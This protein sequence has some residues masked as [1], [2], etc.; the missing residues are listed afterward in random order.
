M[1]GLDYDARMAAL[2][3][4]HGA[5][6]VKLLKSHGRLLH[7]ENFEA[8]LR[9]FTDIIADE[10]G[11]DTLTEAMNWAAGQVAVDPGMADQP[12]ASIH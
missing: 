6:C 4:L 10:V 9:E 8:A 7:A 11:H 12:P 5:A 2:W 1:T 3:I